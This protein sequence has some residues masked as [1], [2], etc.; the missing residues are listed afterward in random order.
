VGYTR[1]GLF[2]DVLQSWQLHRRRSRCPHRPIGHV[3]RHR[4]ARAGSLGATVRPERHAGTLTEHGRRCRRAH[5]GYLT[6]SRQPTTTLRPSLARSAARLPW[7]SLSY[8]RPLDLARVLANVHERHPDVSLNCDSPRTVQ[9]APAIG[10]RRVNAL[11]LAPSN[12][13]P[14]N[15]HVESLPTICLTFKQ[16]GLVVPGP[17]AVTPGGRCRMTG[18]CG[19][20]N[21]AGIR[22]PSSNGVSGCG[23]SQLSRGSLPGAGTS[24]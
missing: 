22:P 4:P 20:R 17:E 10:R 24:S 18:V 2:P 15:R 14:I 21:V 16:V 7:E 23:S 3:K 8:T 6:L 11:S 1:P 9:W 5:S 19:M 12:M 13:S